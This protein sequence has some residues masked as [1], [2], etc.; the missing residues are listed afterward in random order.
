MQEVWKDIAGYEGHYQV[1]NIGRIKSLSRRIDYMG[2]TRYTKEIMLTLRL[3]VF[4]YLRTALYK[5]DKATHC[6][7]HLL[8]WDA[9]GSG[10]RD[11]RRIQVDHINNDKLDNR[12]E[13][14]QLLSARANTTKAILAKGTKR[15]KPIGI[16]YRRNRYE[17]AIIICGK[18]YHLGIFRTEIEASAAYQNK[19]KEVA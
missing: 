3:S 14:L 8:V 5:N 18:R 12:I 13:N 4:G 19:L 9:F 17:A 15:C 6:S 1:S 16:V 10:Q 7:V 11:Y 2:R